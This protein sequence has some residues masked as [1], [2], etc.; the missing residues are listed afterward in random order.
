[1]QEHEHLYRITLIDGNISPRGDTSASN[2]SPPPTVPKPISA[3]DNNKTAFSDRDRPNLSN[4]GNL[5]GQST[6]EKT[7]AVALKTDNL[8]PT[9]KT[10]GAALDTAMGISGLSRGGLAGRR[11]KK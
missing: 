9:E 4:V 5:Q 8:S 10:G 2:D 7:K 1:M 11:K 3:G 6:E